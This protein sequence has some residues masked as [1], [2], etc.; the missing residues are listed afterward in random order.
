[1]ISGWTIG[2]AILIVGLAAVCAMQWH[3]IRKLKK[4]NQEMEERMRETDMS[5]MLSQIQPHFLY[6]SLSA[7]RELCL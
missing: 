2:T 7:I 6:N 3:Q 1:M 4:K 5:I